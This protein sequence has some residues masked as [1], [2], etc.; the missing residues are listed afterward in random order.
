MDWHKKGLWILGTDTDIGK[1]Y[2]TTSIVKS[3]RSKGIDAVPM[4][5][6][7]TGSVSDVQTCLDQVGL[8]LCFER[9][10]LNPYHY[11]PACS[12]HLAGQLTGRY[13]DENFIMETVQTLANNHEFI[14]AE[15]SGG[16]LVPINK[17]KCFIDLVKIVPFPVVLVAR[18]SLGT[19]NHTLLS[20]QVLRSAGI[21][22]LGVVVNDTQ[23]Q[24]GFIRDDNPRTIASFGNVSILA[25]VR[26]K[27]EPQWNSLYEKIFS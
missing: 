10:L 25:D 24:Q 17:T 26:F 22:L 14:V 19:I 6:I 13:V 27:E 4:K 12:P 11:G 7:Q 9:S 3:F 8:N 20:I 23:E 2:I 16:I 15:G 1:T 18:G 5:P 21:C